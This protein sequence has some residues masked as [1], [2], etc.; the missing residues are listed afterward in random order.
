MLT[1]T[2]T[3]LKLLIEK[4]LMC[5]DIIEINKDRS[6]AVYSVILLLLYS[7][8]T[9][10]GDTRDGVPELMSKDARGEAA[11]GECDCKRR[12]S[13][14]CLLDTLH[15]HNSTG[16]SVNTF[17]KKLWRANKHKINTVHTNL[18]TLGLSIIGTAP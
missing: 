9:R 10:A 6:D 7:C 15:S 2:A 12:G 14:L 18:T 11:R 3:S 5:F 8:D 16:H 4:L 13:A 17:G 1:S